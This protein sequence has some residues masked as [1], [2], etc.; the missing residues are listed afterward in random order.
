MLDASSVET[1]AIHL[2]GDAMQW[3]DWLAA[4]HGEPTWDEFVEELLV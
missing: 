1:A 2:E 4:C 3:F